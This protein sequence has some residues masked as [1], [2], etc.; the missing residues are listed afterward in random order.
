M[1]AVFKWLQSLIN[2]VHSRFIFFSVSCMH[3]FRYS[4]IT[5][6]VVLLCNFLCVCCET[7]N[8]FDVTRGWWWSKPSLSN[9][10]KFTNSNKVVGVYGVLARIVNNVKREVRAELVS[11]TINTTR[12][13]LRCQC[14]CIMY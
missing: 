8:D 3:I 2:F 1:F 4:I 12:Q 6:T 7:A 11:A 10:A 13:H 14:L 9:Y 5:I